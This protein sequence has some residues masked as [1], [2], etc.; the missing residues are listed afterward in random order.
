M[1]RTLPILGLAALAAAALGLALWP[2]AS[3]GQQDPQG[4]APAARAEDPR[5]PISRAVL[6][7]SGVAYFQREGV[8]DGDA[9]IDLT[10]PVGDVN[11]LLK[12]LVFHDLGG[13]K[14]RAVSYDGQEPVDKTL[15][16]FA[17]DLTGNP[18]FGQLL[19]QARGEKV[20]VALQPAGRAASGQP[21][22]LTGVIVG[23]E[24]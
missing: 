13:G 19:N 9:R 2:A 5:L 15:K 6:F 18:T 17:L 12:S 14:V 24:S 21:A 1:R 3:P 11:D 16:A 4:A 7:T 10:F 20:E 22:S 23:M 8:I